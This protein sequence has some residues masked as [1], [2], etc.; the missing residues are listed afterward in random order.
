MRYERAGWWR[1]CCFCYPSYL[2]K[3]NS[4]NPRAT[5]DRLTWVPPPSKCV[6]SAASD[7][8]TRWSL[9]DPAGMGSRVYSI[10]KVGTVSE[11][12]RLG[13]LEGGGSALA[14]YI[15]PE[16]GGFCLT[17]HFRRDMR[18]VAVSVLFGTMVGGVGAAIVGL[19][20]S[21]SPASATAATAL[22][23]GSRN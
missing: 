15:H 6:S 17:T 14:R 20:T 5:A 12:E 16:F 13:Q 4:V 2:S 7:V 3:P 1:F 9:R 11:G 22:A 19:N 18:V 21:R 8:A 23:I 10:R